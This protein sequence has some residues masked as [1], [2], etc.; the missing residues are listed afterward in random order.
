MILDSHFQGSSEGIRMNQQKNRRT[1]NRR[2]ALKNLAQGAGATTVI[3]V[4]SR[5]TSQAAAEPL[6]NPSPKAATW[7]HGSTQPADPSLAAADWTPRFLDAHQNETLIAISDIIIPATDTPGAKEAQVNRFL[8]FLLDA[9]DTETRKNFVQALSWFDSYSLQ[10]HKVPFIKLS[11][12]DQIKLLTP[13]SGRRPDLALAAGAGHFRLL[14]GLI[15]RTFYSSEIGYKE[16]GFQDNPY[17][18]EFPGCPNP[19]EHKL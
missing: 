11:A 10:T 9:E 18:A 15:T 16:L 8:D 6:P 4:I 1:I 19:D 14:K 17:Q 12:A 2:Q 13:L 5:V 7:A 3:P